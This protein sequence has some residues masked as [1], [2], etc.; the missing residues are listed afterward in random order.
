MMRNPNDFSIKCDRC[1]HISLI[2]SDSLDYV[3][4]VYDKTDWRRNQI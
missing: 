1:N 3:T 2:E 4:L